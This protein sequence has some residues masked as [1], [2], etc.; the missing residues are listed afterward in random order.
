MEQEQPSS[1]L[2]EWQS[3]GWSI[4]D[5]DCYSMDIGESAGISEHESAGIS[6]HFDIAIIMLILIAFF[7]YGFGA[8]GRYIGNSINAPGVTAFFG[9]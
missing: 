1:M 8:V 9:G 3:Q 5:L 6:E 2:K 7:V 4:S